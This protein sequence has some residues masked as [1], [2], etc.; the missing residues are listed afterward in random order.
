MR[1]PVFTH[2]RIPD[3][4]VITPENLPRP[5]ETGCPWKPADLESVHPQYGSVTVPGEVCKPWEL[6]R[7]SKTNRVTPLLIP[8]P[9]EL[10]GNFLDFSASEAEYEHMR[11]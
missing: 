10:P 4:K 3:G 9:Q 6:E 1:W 5:G 7:A 2:T 11:S 8:Q